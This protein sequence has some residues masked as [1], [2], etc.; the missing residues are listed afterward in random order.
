MTSPA[1]DTLLARIVESGLLEDPIAENGLVYGRASIDAA[2]T[3]V[4]V[5]V[6]PELEDEDEHGDEVDHEALI[7]AVSRILSV[8][9]SR[10]RTVLDE[11]AT[12][13][14]DAV[15]DEPIVEQI[16]LRD[17]L[18]AT[19]VVVFADASLLAFI[20]PKQFPDSRILVQLNEELEVDG[21]EVRELDGSESI[22]FDAIE[23]LLDEI[24]DSDEK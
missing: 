21:V 20:A 8:G 13:I 22:D 17:D 14:D 10:W 7:A 18:E 6:D 11:V 12:D 1:L 16:D 9:E 24:S 4:N 19:S 2:G 5:N 15:D 23:G 3:V